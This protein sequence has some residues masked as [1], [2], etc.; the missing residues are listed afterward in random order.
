M[1]LA[2]TECSALYAKELVPIE[3]DIPGRRIYFG[4]VTEPL[5]E[6]DDPEYDFR[7]CRLLAW[8]VANMKPQL[9]RFLMR[10]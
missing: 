10:Y 6:I 1:R 8:A 5:P 9:E 2:L 4:A 7:S 3:G